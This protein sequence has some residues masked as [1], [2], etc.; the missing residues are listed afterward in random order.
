MNVF[1]EVTNAAKTYLSGRV[2]PITTTALQGHVAAMVRGISDREIFETLRLATSTALAS[3][4]RRGE[5]R[6][7][8]MFGKATTVRPWLW[9]DYGLPN[10]ELAQQKSRKDEAENRK[11]DAINRIRATGQTLIADYL[12]EYT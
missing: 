7:G 1:D 9:A 5:P 3:Y 12:E 8:K 6:A 2:D 4:C 10:D 11:R